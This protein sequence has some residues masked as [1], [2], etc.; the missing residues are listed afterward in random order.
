MH[1]GE[2]QKTCPRTRLAIWLALATAAAVAWLAVETRY[3]EWVLGGKRIDLVIH[4]DASAL[5]TTAP[6]VFVLYDRAALSP[7]ARALGLFQCRP[8]ERVRSFFPVRCRSVEIADNSIVLRGVGAGP[9]SRILFVCGD[10]Q[11]HADVPRGSKLIDNTLVI[12]IE[13]SLRHES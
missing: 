8:P 5:R 11:Y 2:E 3:Y 12:R 10:R 4:C 1:K 6:E 13:R 9:I 7:P